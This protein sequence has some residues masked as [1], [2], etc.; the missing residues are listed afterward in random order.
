MS[1]ATLEMPAALPQAGNHNLNVEDCYQCGKCT[2]GCPVADRMDLMPNQIVRLVQ[3]GQID[4]AA[5]SDAI[6]QCVSCQTCTTRC[7]KL[8]DCAGVMDMLR[9]RSVERAENSESQH[10]T[11]LFQKAFLANIRRNG[12]L[13]ELELVGAFKTSA[14]LDDL[15]I[16]FL[17]KDAMLAPRMRARGKLKLN[18]AKVNDRE[19]VSRI[20]GRCLGD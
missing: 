15:A 8:V 17:F 11:V 19:V 5:A 1:T 2:A 13:N 10:R 9:Q 3:L 4:R 7:P 6:W 14:F 16:P 20:F 12:R 18:G